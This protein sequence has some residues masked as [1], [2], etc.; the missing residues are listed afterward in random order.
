MTPRIED[1]K[2]LKQ[3]EDL[4]IEQLLSKGKTQSTAKNYRTD[5]NQF[6]KFLEKENSSSLFPF[7]P[8]LS[9]GEKYQNWLKKDNLDNTVRRRIQ[10]LRLFLDYLANKKIVEQNNFK[11]LKTVPKTIRPINAPSFNEI[12]DIHNAFEFNYLEK[13]S[14]KEIVEKR[15]LFILYLIYGVGLSVSQVSELKRSDIIKI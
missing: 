2:S 15:N 12:V 6:N 14:L 10:S 8:S 3:F 5:L 4:F 13:A 1:I 7:N 9:L 11:Q